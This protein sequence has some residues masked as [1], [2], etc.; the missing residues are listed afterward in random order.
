MI[1]ILCSATRR[2]YRSY[3]RSN[4]DSTPIIRHNS[5]H[6]ISRDI[7]GYTARSII[8][9]NSNEERAAD[10]LSAR[11]SKEYAAPHC[12]WPTLVTLARRGIRRFNAQRGACGGC[13][14]CGCAAPP[15]DLRAPM[16]PADTLA[17]RL[18]L[19]THNSPLP[20]VQIQRYA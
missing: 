3:S 20:I 9:I 12:E 18:V 6:F 1:G 11:P 17:T 19:N 7:R 8:V 5:I 2:S 13:A 10:S 15:C 4:L 14:A 16:R